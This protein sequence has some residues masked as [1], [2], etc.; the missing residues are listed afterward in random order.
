MSDNLQLAA[1]TRD[2]KGKG[3]SRR[4]RRLEGKLPAIVYGNG[5]PSNV[6]IEQ[7][8][9]LKLLENE[10]TY[11]SILDLV[12]DGKAEPVLLKDLQ[13]HPAKNLVLHAD[14]QRIDLKKTINVNVPL[15]FI[16]EDTCKGVKIGGGN[17]SRLQTSVELSCLPTALP[18]YIEVDMLEQELGDVLHISDLALPEG[19][20]SIALEH[21]HDLA[22]AQINAPKAIVEEETGAPEAAADEDTEGDNADDA[23]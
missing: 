20:T 9:L 17:I 13:R 16:N 10:A 22:I 12:V 11:S 19:V 5:E 4:L 1:T 8:E 23:E 2:V 14:F 21:E 6:S 3:A 18:E 15:H 7:K